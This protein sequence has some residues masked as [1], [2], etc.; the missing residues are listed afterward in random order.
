MVYFCKEAC[1]VILWIPNLNI[2]GFFFQERIFREQI[3]KIFF[4]KNY[5]AKD[6]QS[7]GHDVDKIMVLFISIDFSGRVYCI[8]TFACEAIV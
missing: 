4:K 5:T 6:F 1:T 8:Y 7:I 3:I 2:V